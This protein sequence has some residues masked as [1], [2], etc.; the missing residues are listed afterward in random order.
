MPGGWAAA[1]TPGPTVSKLPLGGMVGRESEGAVQ[2]VGLRVSL[3][4]HS[5][6]AG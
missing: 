5:P 2:R 6:V 1:P 3:I 4:P